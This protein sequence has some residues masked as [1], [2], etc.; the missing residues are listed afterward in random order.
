VTILVR[1]VGAVVV[2]MALV[3]LV[4]A[5]GGDDDG[6]TN[7]DADSEGAT[8]D[9]YADSICA[10]GL[11]WFQN[12]AAIQVSLQ[13][14]QVATTSDALSYVQAKLGDAVTATRQLADQIRRATPPPTDAG[15]QVE[16]TLEEK[17]DA[18]A[19]RM[20]AY[21]QSVIAEGSGGVTNATTVAAKL[22]TAADEARAA[23]ADPTLPDAP[24]EARD[25]VAASSTCQEL[26]R[27]A[28]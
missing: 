25:A 8:M 7:A 11:D 20:E 4:G 28:E 15:A 13:P 10:A 1:R 27:A 14:A 24:P 12:I 6:N 2:A 21:A 19:S 22:N 18:L 5:C 23:F 16:Q 9:S 26:Q 17:L 3:F